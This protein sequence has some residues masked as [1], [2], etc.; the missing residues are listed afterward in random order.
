MA[1]I[2]FHCGRHCS[3]LLQLPY[4]PGK[5][6]LGGSIH[7]PRKNRTVVG[8]YALDGSY[9]VQRSKFLSPARIDRD[10]ENL[11]ALTGNNSSAQDT[12]MLPRPSALHDIAGAISVI[13]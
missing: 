5:H 7:G 8:A 10:G 3:R 9:S 6:T 11:R 2:R 13:Q 4:L 1:V 12:Q